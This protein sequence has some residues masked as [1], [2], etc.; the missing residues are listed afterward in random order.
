M[1]NF[2]ALLKKNKKPLVP[3]VAGPIVPRKPLTALQ[4]AAA[5]LATKAKAKAAA[6]W[7]PGDK[8]ESSELKLAVSVATTRVL[9]KRMDA[10][11]KAKDMSRSEL[12][13]KAM[14][15]YL[16]TQGA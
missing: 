14:R 9:L 2:K 10:Y 8:K 7:K 6:S 15:T 11:A 12:F 13:R 5:K 4:I 1:V 16:T 3:V